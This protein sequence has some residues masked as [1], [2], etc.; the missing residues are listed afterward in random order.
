[1]LSQRRTTFQP[2]FKVKQNDVSVSWLPLLPLG[3]V[4]T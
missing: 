1:M 2:Y 3:G 4:H